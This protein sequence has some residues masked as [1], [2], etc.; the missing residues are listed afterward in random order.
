MECTS[1]TTIYYEGLEWGITEIGTA[2][3]S[4]GL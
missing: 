4:L 2:A 1:L 3:F